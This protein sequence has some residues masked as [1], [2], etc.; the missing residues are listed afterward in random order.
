[1]VSNKSA[2]LDSQRICLEQNP[3]VQVRYS[4][5]SHVPASADVVE[6]N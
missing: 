2:N 5:G 3:E 1:M 4:C 6:S